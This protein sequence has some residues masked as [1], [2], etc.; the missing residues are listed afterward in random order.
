VTFRCDV[1]TY[2]E[3][4]WRR[5][6]ASLFYDGMAAF[7]ENAAPRYLLSMAVA[8]DGIMATAGYLRM[9]LFRLSSARMRGWAGRHGARSG[10]FCLACAIIAA[11]S[12][13]VA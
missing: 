4:V 9:T 10:N 2:Q 8:K 12:P 6:R 1:W 7:L 13:S 5:W 11:L 3:N